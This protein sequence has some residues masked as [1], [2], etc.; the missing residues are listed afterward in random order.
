MSRRN[1]RKKMQEAEGQKRKAASA[2]HADLHPETKKSVLAVFFFIVAALF[3]LSYIGKGGSAGGYLFRMFDWLLGRGYFFAPLA[4]VLVGFSLLFSEK[5]KILG[6]TLLG[7]TL[8]LISSLTLLDIIFGIR[9]GGIIGFLTS[10]PLL[11]LFDS[12]ASLIISG[13]AFAVSVL[14]MLNVPIWRK[15][16]VT[17]K[18]EEMEQTVADKAEMPAHTI[19]NQIGNA[20][21]SAIEKREG[22]SN[23]AVSA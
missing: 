3:V 1:H 4:S 11:K 13:G 18:E 15:K 22:N 16:E 5:R 21:A 8:F 6:A 19:L 7:G 20:L 9:T 17:G 12:L 14:L 10:A 23:T 2:W